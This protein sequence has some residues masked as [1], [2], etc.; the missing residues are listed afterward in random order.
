M[1]IG[2]KVQAKT[3]REMNSRTDEEPGV[4]CSEA[5]S[6]EILGNSIGTNIYLQG[7]KQSNIN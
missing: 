7:K 4:Q 6:Q 5:K 1:K 2:L 3:N